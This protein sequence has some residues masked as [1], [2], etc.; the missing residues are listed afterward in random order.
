MD[1]DLIPNIKA[2]AL[3][4]SSGSTETLLPRLEIRGWEKSRCLKVAFV[5]KHENLENALRIHDA[6][7][8]ALTE[9]C[10]EFWDGFREAVGA[11]SPKRPILRKGKERERV[12]NLWLEI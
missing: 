2:T 9:L 1:D 5:K 11:W 10:N 8:T 4:E 12:L 7:G 6:V 3:R